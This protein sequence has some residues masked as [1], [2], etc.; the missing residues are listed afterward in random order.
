MKIVNLNAEQFDEFAENHKYKNY[1]Q[2]SEYANLIKNFGYHTQFLGITD[3]DN[4]LIGATLIIYKE[5][6]MRNKIGYAPR[7]ILFDYE[8]LETLK[9]MITILKKT[10]NKGKFIMFRIDPYIPKTIR[11]KKGEI[12]NINQKAETII[13][14][15]QSVG[16]KYKGENLYFETEKPRWEALVIL[17][18][19]IREIFSKFDK[20]T[21]NKIRRAANLGI[22][23]TKDKSNDIT[24]LYNFI[25][26]KDHNKI[27]FYKK[28]ISSFGEKVDLYYAK[29]NTE[30]FIINS[31]KSY[32]EEIE[33]NN[34]LASIIQNVD[35]NEVEK[36]DYITKKI[37]SDELVQ[38]Y[39]DTM[40]LAT[41]LLREYP[42]GLK[43]A[44]SLVIKYDNA[45]FIFVD[46]IDEN[47]RNLNASY[48]MR[49]KMIEEYNNDNFKYINLNGITGDLKKQNKYSGLNET[50]LGFDSTITE[51]IGEFDII[52]NNFNYN[53]YKNLN[54]KH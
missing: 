36:N 43:I 35:M 39:K 22:E 40:I 47:Y 2:S 37:E 41:R 38:T 50:K 42:D 54:K 34:K 6:F 27:E 4:Q 14:N 21:R 53:L 29:I 48:L 28:L 25:K 1:Y 17:K 13:E 3:E 9:E 16:F 8:N 15:L 20:R 45:A 44:G 52:I 7:G 33:N 30:T 19:D 26:D 24:D 10:L 49:W 51:Y 5:I 11:N 23:V 46:G 12:L 18:R 32:E 31:R